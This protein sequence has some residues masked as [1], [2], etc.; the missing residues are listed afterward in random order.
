MV[1]KTGAEALELLDKTKFD[2]ILMDI[3]LGRGLSGIEVTK[4]IR[5][6]KGYEDVPIVAMTAYAML[7]DK[8]DF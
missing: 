8:E 7:G 3:N 6:M 5:L 1:A 2:L 4:Q